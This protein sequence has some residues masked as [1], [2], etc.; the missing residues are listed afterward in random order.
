MTDLTMNYASPDAATQPVRSAWDSAKGEVFALAFHSVASACF[1]MACLLSSG[2]FAIGAAI[3]ALAN[4]TT[5]V[6][7][8]NRLR[9]KLSQIPATMPDRPDDATAQIGC[10]PA[11]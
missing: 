11:V 9:K 6:R 10:A 4:G 7:N 2:S 5:A 1:F 3:I 8:T